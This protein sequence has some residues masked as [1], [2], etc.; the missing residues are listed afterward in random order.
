MEDRFVFNKLIKGISKEER[1]RMLE[2]MHYI[3]PLNDLPLKEEFIEDEYNYE[4]SYKSFSIFEKIIVFFRTL[5]SSKER[6]TVIE[7]LSMEKL[8]KKLEKEFPELISYNQKKYLNKLY[9]EVNKLSDS[10]NVFRNTLP[11]VMKSH[12]SDF[13]VFLVG[14]YFPE[15]EENLISVI[16]P[17]IASENF[18]FENSF[19][20]K[21]HIEFGID[22]VLSELDTEKKKII[23]KE[24]KKLHVLH[25]LSNFNF[26]RII[27]AFAYDEA[28]DGY[29][30]NFTDIRK[31]LHSLTD[32]LFSL[33]IL[34]AVDTL[35]ALFMFEHESAKSENTDD[36]EKILKLKM[37]IV[38]KTF[39]IIRNFN[40]KI[41]LNSILCLVNRNMNFSPAHIGGAED[42]YVLFRQYWYRE[43]DILMDKY[44]EEKKRIQLEEDAAFFLNISGKAVL[45]HYKKGLWADGK[46]VKFE[47]TVGFIYTFIDKIFNRELNKALK[48][49]LIDGQFYKEQNRMDYNKSYGTIIE[50]FDKIKLLNNKLSV[51]GEYFS[52]INKLDQEIGDESGKNQINE[53]IN[54]VDQEF[55]KIIISFN[56][57]LSLLI[58]VIFGIIQGEMG[59]AYDTLS[60]LGYIGKG[61]N[62]NLISQ[63]N[64]IRFK[65]DE[66]RNISYQLYDLEKN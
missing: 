13:I 1:L 39:T 60:N 14:L 54:F 42:W 18:E 9:L 27:S 57:A 29:S 15:I 31:P 26:D 63:L 23:Y 49:I 38:D 43:F 53:I 19:Q 45:S 65:L 64:D 62:K 21:R 8:A 28:E 33:N 4:K 36:L 58:D 17:D 44:I 12:K 35:N 51:N 5:F 37:S 55:K 66:A 2:K 41:P 46:S 7:S 47:A 20:L 24:I 11:F 50:T 6:D 56:E 30:C 52:Q 59:G 40:T 32:I 3:T 16:D 22:E 61:E 34:P 48:L 10:L 25:V